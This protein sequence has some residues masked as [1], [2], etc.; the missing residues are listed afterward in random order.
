M[1]RITLSALQP[2]GTP[3][4]VDL[5][6]LRVSRGDRKKV[7]THG[8]KIAAAMRA[9]DGD[10]DKVDDEALEAG[11]FD[12]LDALIFYWVQGWSLTWA[13]TVDAPPERATAP[14]PLPKNDPAVLELLDLEVGTEIEDALQPVMARMTGRKVSASDVG[15]PQSPSEPSSD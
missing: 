13:E 6:E 15:D 5:R 4:W 7:L 9:A 11:G 10:P 8:N 1:P 3:H 2:D 14:L 12:F